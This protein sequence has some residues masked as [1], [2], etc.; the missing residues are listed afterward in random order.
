MHPDEGDGMAANW[1]QL[2]DKIALLLNKRKVQSSTSKDQR[3]ILKKWLE[4]ESDVTI[5]KSKNLFE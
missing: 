3:Q 4:K 5:G 2:S 1:P